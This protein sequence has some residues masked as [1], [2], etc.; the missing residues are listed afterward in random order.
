V[1]GVATA[2]VAGVATAAVAVTTIAV[3]ELAV[4]TVMTL[5]HEVQTGTGGVIM[6]QLEVLRVTVETGQVG[7]IVL[8]V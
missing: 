8:V 3:P 2:W 4:L 5:T 6:G 1:A 7:H